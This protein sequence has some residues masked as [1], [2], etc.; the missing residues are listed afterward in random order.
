MS[1]EDDIRKARR[2]PLS[3]DKM[4]ELLVKLRK[5]ATASLTFVKVIQVLDALGW[6]ATPALGWTPRH[7]TFQGEEQLVDAD[8]NRFTLNVLTE[9]HTRL[10]REQV[11]E[12]PDV[13]SAVGAVVV[14]DVGDIKEGTGHRPFPIYYF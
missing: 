1:I 13:P 10:A 3:E 14:M 4:K 12:L 5:G 9:L 8:S 2:R 7:Y 11:A 6:K